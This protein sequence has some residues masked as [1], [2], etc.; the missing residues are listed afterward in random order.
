MTFLGVNYYFTKGMHSYA[1][2]E[3]PVFPMWAWIT[4]LAVIVF[5]VI[6]GLKERSNKKYKEEEEE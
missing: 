6:A 4:I 5:I 3:T 2:G 1:S